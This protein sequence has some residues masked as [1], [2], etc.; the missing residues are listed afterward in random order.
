MSKAM[1]AGRWAK[2]AAASGADG[3][4]LLLT[5]GF[6]WRSLGTV[7]PPAAAAHLVWSVSTMASP[8][9]HPSGWRSHSRCSLSQVQRQHRVACDVMQSCKHQ[10]ESCAMGTS[11]QGKDYN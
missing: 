1:A 2:A 11:A 8:V 4:S 9:G 6:F 10:T 3:L 7:T 5:Q